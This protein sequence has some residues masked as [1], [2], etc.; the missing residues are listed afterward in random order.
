MEE[1]LFGILYPDIEPDFP[2][3][4]VWLEGMERN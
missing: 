3:G 1:I 2:T 4:K